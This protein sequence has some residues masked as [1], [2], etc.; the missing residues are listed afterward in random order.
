MTAT[1]FA[2]LHTGWPE[3]LADTGSGHNI[4]G[5]VFVECRAMYRE[6]GDETR[7]SLGE[8]EFVNGIAAMSASGGYGPTKACLGIVGN[9]ENLGLGIVKTQQRPGQDQVLPLLRQP[10]RAEHCSPPPFARL[11][12]LAR[13]ASRR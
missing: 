1:N 10:C 3:L 13:A 7:R 4:V 8:T 11:A 6:D 2:F 12:R 9:V 5:T